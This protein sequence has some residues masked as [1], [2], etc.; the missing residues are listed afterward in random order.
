MP[1]P[2]KP[3]EQLIG[4]TIAGCRVESILGAGG[5]GV[6]Y[7]AHQERLDAPVALKVIR[8]AYSDN[9]NLIAR[10]EREARGIAKLRGKTNH[11]VQVYDFGRDEA[12]GIYYISMEFV[13]GQGVDQILKAEGAIDP[14]A[15]AKIIKEAAE[16]LEVARQLGLV[17][18]D[19]KPENLLLTADGVTKITD[20]GLAK[21]MATETDI[22]VSGQILGTPAYMSPQQARG[23]KVDHSTDIYS[24]GASLYALL[25][26]KRPYDSDTALGM[27][28]KHVSDPVPDAIAAGH[29]VPP[30]L[31][32]VVKRCMAKE[33]ADRYATGGELAHALDQFLWS[34][35][36][37]VTPSGTTHDPPADDA[38]DPVVSDI[39]VV[40][41]EISSAVA[42]AAAALDDTNPTVGADEAS[43]TIGM[44]DLTVHDTPAPAPPAPAKGSPVPLLAGAVVLLALI[45]GGLWAAGVFDGATPAPAPAPA[46]EP[47]KVSLPAPESPMEGAVL[48]SGDVEVRGTL[49]DAR[50]G[51]WVTVNGQYV[52]VI[53]GAYRT[54][55]TLPDGPHKLAIAVGVGN[56]G[57]AEQ[58]V[59][60]HVDATP[61]VVR[62]GK[63][64]TDVVVTRDETL[65][66]AGTVRDEGGAPGALTLMLGNTGIALADGAFEH[67]VTLREGEQTLVLV[68]KD[69]AGRTTDYPLTVTRDS[70]PPALELTS[71]TPGTTRVNDGVLTI[72]GRLQDAGEITLT[73]GG[74]TVKVAADGAF[75]HLVDLDDGTNT[76][77]LAWSD[78]AG[79]TASHTITVA[80]ES[81]PDGITADPQGDG[82][83]C[84]ADGAAM[85][86]VGSGDT[87]FFIDQFEVTVARY[88]KFLDAA[89]AGAAAHEPLR[90]ARQNVPERQRHPVTG[91]S[92][93]NA[94][95][96][97]E[98]AGKT[99]PTEAQW[100]QAAGESAYPWGDDAPGAGQ[101]VFGR[102]PGPGAGPDAVGSAAGD[103]SAS[104]IHDLGGNLAEWCA[105]EPGAPL[106]PVRGGHWAAESESACKRDA[107]RTARLGDRQYTVGF[108]CVKAVN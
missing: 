87:R 38:S 21:G 17:H 14:K 27:A 69:G 101:V 68:A 44:Q 20:F 64:S 88:A 35:S 11:V 45:G 80:Y 9:E 53:D 31:N 70:T 108:R 97:A 13:E 90:W 75:N 15:A 5:M 49:V 28:M 54:T 107:R 100:A 25:T 98:W 96:Y 1:A 71:P 63:P 76:F 99:L 18:R 77:A 86:S 73:I 39:L 79:N 61:P 23:E 40:D 7:R 93:E 72:A 3:E 47:A 55:L 6:V 67:T 94:A 51:T 32:E 8:R 85:R 42:D 50:P 52:D 92:W 57:H 30:D 37:L 19:I 10:F 48:D 65:T 22:S 74:E 16:G 102:E 60:F 81:L 43:A 84:T 34:R 2:S 24:L 29:D 4:E 46:P 59:T 83:R 33:P 26:G 106:Q 62:L 95:A 78:A 66:L 91:V 89:G 104:G 58:S 103:V 105:G 82:Y 56:A 36:T 12:H 41:E